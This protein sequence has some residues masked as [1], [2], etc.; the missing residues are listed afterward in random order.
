MIK[1]EMNKLYL[2]VILEN[3]LGLCQNN[4]WYQTESLTLD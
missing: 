4:D 3:H 1:I 2:V